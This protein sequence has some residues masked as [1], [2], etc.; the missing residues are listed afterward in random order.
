[1]YLCRYLQRV[2]WVS[3]ML[4]DGWRAAALAFIEFVILKI[5]LLYETRVLHDFI[6]I[7]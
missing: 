5:K 1:M 4:T 7:F 2:V 3:N 6:F